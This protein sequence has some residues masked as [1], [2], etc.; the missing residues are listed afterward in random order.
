MLRPHELWWGREVKLLDGTSVSMED[1]LANAPVYA[2]ATGQKPGCGFPLI[3]M[4]GM[5]SRSS[6]AWLGYATSPKPRHDPALSVDLVRKHVRPG[7]VVVADRAYCALLDAGLDPGPWGRRPP[8][9]CT[10]RASRAL[11]LVRRTR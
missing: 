1:T 4:A 3:Y 2:H 5:F 7:D 10:R 6:G 9:G 11:G 8:C